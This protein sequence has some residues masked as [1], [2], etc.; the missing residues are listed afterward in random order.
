M[1]GVKQ[2]HARRADLVVHQVLQRVEQAAAVVVDRPDRQSLEQLRKRLLHQ[3]PV[4]QHVRHAG[5]A[6]QIVFQ[7]VD[8]AVAVAHQVG[9]RDVAPDAAWAGSGRR[10][11]GGTPLA[12]A[13]TCS[14]I[15]PSLTIRCSW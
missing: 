4:L 8:L 5:G 10:T 14:G 15:T 3:L 7:H 9:A 13:T 11:V 12:V 6:A 2:R 1:P